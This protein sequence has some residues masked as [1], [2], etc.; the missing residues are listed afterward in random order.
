VAGLSLSG[1]A[2]LPRRSAPAR[3]DAVRLVLTLLLING[4]VPGL[5]EIAEAAVHYAVEGHL[6]HS[7]A[8][9]GD[10]GDQGHEHGCGTTEHVCQCCG[11]MT[12]LA[13][14]AGVEVPPQPAR[15]GPPV[16]GPSLLSLDA[17]APPL[18]PPIAS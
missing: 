15:A 10:L 6:A 14:S 1:G 9:H 11:S 3:F 17:P 12:V 16:L 4:L 13:T 7:D 8:D 18:R 2:G 5:G